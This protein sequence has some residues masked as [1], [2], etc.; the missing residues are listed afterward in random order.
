MT[1]LKDSINGL[2]EAVDRLLAERDALA[3]EVRLLNDDLAQ[4][5]SE[6]D[7]V[8]SQRDEAEAAFKEKIESLPHTEDGQPIVPGMKLYVAHPSD[9]D[10]PDLVTD[11]RPV[12]TY[13]TAK[14][15]VVDPHYSQ[16]KMFADREAAK[17]DAEADRAAA[18]AAKENARG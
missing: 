13:F 15:Y 7:W 1:D 4:S 14:A 2:S 8:V 10:R 6:R 18:L 17:V 16:F 9:W 3:R 12:L 5:R 11:G